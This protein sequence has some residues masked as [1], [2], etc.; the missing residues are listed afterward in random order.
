VCVAVYMCTCVY[1]FNS[2]MLCQGTAE[3]QYFYTEQS[4]L[5]KKCGSLIVITLD[6]YNMG[7]RYYMIV[8]TLPLGPCGP[9]CSCVYF[10]QITRAHVITIT[11][12]SVIKIENFQRRIGIA[13]K[14]HETRRGHWDGNVNHKSLF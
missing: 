6:S 2:C 5:K 4:S 7:T 1:M 9:S 10:R 12:T 11:Y 8:I 14:S 13:E 3:K